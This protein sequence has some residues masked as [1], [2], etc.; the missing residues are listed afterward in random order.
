MGERAL[1]SLVDVVDSVEGWLSRE[2]AALLIEL[3]AAVPADEAIVEIGNYRGRSTVALGLGAELGGATVYSVDPHDVFA[4]ARGG[5]FGPHDQAQL[6]AN[7]V[8]TSVGARVRVIGLRSQQVA[9]SWPQRDVRLLFLD[10]DHRYAAVRGDYE[11]W[12]PHLLP[13]AEVL[14]DDCDFTDVDRWIGELVA[15]GRVRAIERVGK[16]ARCRRSASA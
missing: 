4:G 11:S 2:Q 12:E 15:A 16:L 1:D 8:R 10:G 7:L 3:A 6:Y 9:Q 5:R 14:F 13:D